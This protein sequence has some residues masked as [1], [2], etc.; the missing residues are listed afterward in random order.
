MLH[1]QSHK[2]A[3]DDLDITLKDIHDDIEVT[4]HYH[5]FPEGILRRSSTVRNGTGQAL[6][7]ESAQSATWNLPGGTGYRLTYLSGRWAAE[8]Q[9]NQE[10]IHEGSKIIESRL[11]HT[12]HNFN[13]WFAIDSGNSSEAN[14]PVWFGAL[15]ASLVA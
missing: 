14:G 7:I 9:M 12:G 3:G 1:Y 10:P 8:T 11:G 2:I 6:T 15:G 5:V 13:P 4:L